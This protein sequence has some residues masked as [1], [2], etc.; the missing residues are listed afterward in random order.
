M[1]VRFPA[2]LCLSLLLVSCEKEKQ[3]VQISEDEVP[4]KR[5]TKSDRPASLKE[6]KKASDQRRAA[7]E[8]AGNLPQGEERNQA[9]AQWVWDTFEIDPKLAR[10]GFGLLTPGT[11]EM[12]RL[13][14]HYAMRLAEQD[15]DEAKSW[16][17]SLESD[18]E[19]SLA[20]GMI[21]VVIAEQDP[22]SAARLLS[23]SGIGGHDFDVAVVQVVQRWAD[24]SPEK[25]AEWVTRFKKGDARAAGV[26]AITSSWI[27][28]DQDA[29][30]R[31]I[32]SL[33]NEHIRQEA[34]T[35]FAETVQGQPP[36]LRESM[37]EKA[38]PEMRSSFEELEARAR[39]AEENPEN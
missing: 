33:T 8:Q 39:E 34:I 11:P 23:D 3:A 14:E 4:A 19:K 24:T 10:E 5:V 38:T 26:K 20:Y 22:E 37:L 31:W 25:A 35:G 9:I 32:S 29:A 13:L 2:A 16:A 1:T 27:T 7:L 15:V 30:V 18:E 12:N 17:S 28:R 36:L 6:S 21:A